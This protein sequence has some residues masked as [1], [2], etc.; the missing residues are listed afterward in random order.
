[1]PA[2]LGWHSYAYCD[3]LNETY[4][5]GTPLFR[6]HYEPVRPLGQQIH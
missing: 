4:L 3:T 5:N 1:M 2:R 6:A